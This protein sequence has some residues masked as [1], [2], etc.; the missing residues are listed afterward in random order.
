MND[1]N[2]IYVEEYDDNPYVFLYG[3]TLRNVVVT[4]DN[5]SESYGYLSCGQICALTLEEVESMVEGIKRVCIDFQIKYL[6][7]R[8]FF[9]HNSLAL[10]SG[11][12]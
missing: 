2:I 1:K 7:P 10:E 9:K 3:Q 8:S 5:L 4:I 11:E 6:S 12:L